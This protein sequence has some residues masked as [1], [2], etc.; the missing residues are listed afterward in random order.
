[1][2]CVWGDM[3]YLIDL[4]NNTIAEPERRLGRKRIVKGLGEIRQLFHIYSQCY[5]TGSCVNF[6]CIRI[7]LY[8]GQTNPQYIYSLLLPFSQRIT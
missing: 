6:L 1:M 4:Y 5:I 2:S 8:L 7:V 3:V